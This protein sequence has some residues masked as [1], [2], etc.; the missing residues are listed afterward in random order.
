MAY[1][2]QSRKQEVAPKV[3]ALLKK[4]DLKGTLSVDNHSTVVLK[5]TSGDLDFIGNSNATIDNRPGGFRGGVPAST[6]ISVNVY[7]FHNHFT[8][9][10]LNFLVDV[11]DV[12]HEGNHDNSDI[13]SDFFNVGWY[14]DINI[15]KW[16]KPYIY[17]KH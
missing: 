4:Y 1:Y 8:G 10:C 6:Y 12:L 15:G 9:E 14:V 16:N 7:H 3:K 13:Q 17:N 11:M 2:S 5:I